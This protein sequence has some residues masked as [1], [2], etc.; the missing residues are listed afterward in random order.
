[1]LQIDLANLK[2]YSFHGLYPEE[3]FLGGEFEL[4]LSVMFEES[5][6]LISDLKNSINYVDLYEIIEK[7]MMTSTP[8]LETIIM[9][10]SNSIYEKYSFIKMITISL[11][12]LHPPITKMQGSV[13]V[14]WHKTY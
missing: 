6:N 14:S 7:R 4:N 13:S 8:L 9:D 2:F 5:V 11:A 12:K 3:V 1:M 10:I